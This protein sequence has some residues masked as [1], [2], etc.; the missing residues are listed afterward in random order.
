MEAATTAASSDIE[1]ISSP[2]FGSENG[3]G[4]GKLH[5]GSNRRLRDK[6]GTKLG[7]AR[8][9]SEVSGISVCSDS[10]DSAKPESTNAL[11]SRNRTIQK[12]LQD[13]TEL[14]EARKVKL[15]ELSKQ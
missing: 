11:E 9:S 13:M 3:N 6:Y 4:N 8:S 15:V 7:H 12:K 2:I 14:L 1:V 10:A 5:A